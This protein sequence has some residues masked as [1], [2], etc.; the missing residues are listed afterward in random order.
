M[1]LTT[2][3]KN[4]LIDL[5]E[6]GYSEEEAIEIADEEL[7]SYVDNKIDEMKEKRSTINEN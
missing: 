1:N 6:E 3:Y 5:S 4:R 7:R 2:I